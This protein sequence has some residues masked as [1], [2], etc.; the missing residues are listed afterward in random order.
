M[1]ADKKYSQQ[2]AIERVVHE[3][4]IGTRK[5]FKIIADKYRSQRKIFGLRFNLI[6][7]IY[8]F[9]LIFISFER[10]LL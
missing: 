1:P 9:E 10:R 3:N 7:K 4:A 8:N 6:A 2:L 5:G